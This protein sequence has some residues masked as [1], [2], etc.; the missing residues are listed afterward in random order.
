MA[1][2]FKEILPSIMITGK[3]V[4]ET[5]DDYK[6]YIPFII[7]KALSHHLDC[8]SYA[9]DMNIRHDLSNELQYKYLMNKVRKYRRNFIPWNKKSYDTRLDVISEYY[10]VSYEKA[11]DILPILTEEQFETIKRLI[12]KGGMDNG[13]K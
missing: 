11:L 12:D 10:D 4:L 6:D 8:V 9:Q 1:D 5:E 13:K 7:N 3:P 2:L